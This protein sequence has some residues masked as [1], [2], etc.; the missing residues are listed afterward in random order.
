MK[1]TFDIIV[2]SIALLFQ[3]YV[4]EVVEYY[5][6]LSKLSKPLLEKQKERQNIKYVPNKTANGHASDKK[7][8]NKPINKREVD[9][10]FRGHPK[11]REELWNE[12]FLNK[13]SAFDQNPSLIVLLH[14]LTLRYLNDCTPVILYDSEVA[15]E[16]EHLFKDLFKDF[17]V[18]FVHGKIDTDDKLINP[19]LL[20]PVRECVHFIVFLTDLRTTSKVIGMQAS[21]KVVI[22]ARTSQWAVQEYLVSSL[23]RKF[24]NLLVIGQSFKDEDD[25]LEAPYI[26]YTHELYIDGLGASRPVVLTSWSHGKYSRDVE[27]FPHKMQ[28]G[29]AGHRFIIAAADQPPFVVRRVKSDLDGGN[30]RVIWDGIEIRILK[31]LGERNNFSIE[32]KEPQEL[33][34]GSSDAV[35]KEIAMG[36]ADVGIA[37][38]YLTNQ[39]IQ[40]MDMTA[41]H[42]QDCAVF[43]TLL[44]TALPRYRAI[45]GP[46]HWHVWVAL[47]FTYLIGIFPLAFSDKHT[48]RHLLNDSGEIENMFWYVFGTF[49]NC[50]TFVGKNSWSKT[51]KIT[52]RLLIGWYWI[53]TIIITSCYTGSIIAFVTLP[54][55]PETIDSIDQLLRGFFRIGTLDHGGWER[56][57]FNSSDPKTNKLLSRMSF[58]PNVEAGI[59]NTTK[60]FFW[61]YA[62]LGSKAELEYIVQANFSLTK[63]K[64][65]TLHI[66]NECFVPFGVSIGFPN[67]SLYTAKLSGDIQRMSQSGL[68]NKIVDEVRWEIQ[69][70][71]T[72][73]LLAASSSGSIKIVSA[74]EKGLTLEDT[75]GMF[76]LLA[77]G[78]IIAAAA[79]ISEWM[80]GCNRKCRPKKKINS[81]DRK[82]LSVNSRENL[83]PTPKSDVSSEIKFITDD[84]DVDSRV[85]FNQRPYSAGSRDTLDGH[86]I[87][88][89]DETIIV[90]Q[91]VD[92]DRWEYRR[93]SSMDLDKEVQEIFERDQRKRRFQSESILDS[94]NISR[95]HTASKSA[96]GDPVISSTI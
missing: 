33:H 74:E 19:D 77:A 39:R 58:V 2:I 45:L 91:S 26:L 43:V 24:V 86:T 78:A 4:C 21:S 51:T 3:V 88:V 93:S 71:T 72:G 53:F 38:M 46:F 20:K 8:K 64:R 48:L 82:I 49:T 18:T 1:V 62:F 83:I 30:P 57:F 17:P 16:E 27:L 54:V 87:H 23:S 61:N 32:I 6:S 52:T 14:N 70:S 35:A 5:P 9:T 59:R 96:F 41:A 7:P 94:K 81:A 31:L 76:L 55:F 84:D 15:S 50:F 13:S 34:L 95:H 79:L 69:R 25:K 65:A 75:Q 85:Y 11:T 29:Y 12:H 36:R 68:L 47:T 67:Q 22:V 92:T 37:G 66:S 89:T 60:A 10:A 42:S 28:Q 44:S 40:E 90:H 73:K 56:W 80:G 63:S